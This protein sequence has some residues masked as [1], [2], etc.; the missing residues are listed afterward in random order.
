M[1]W[2]GTIGNV[3]NG[4]NSITQATLGGINAAQQNKQIQQ[5]Q[6]KMRQDQENLMRSE[7]K[8]NKAEANAINSAS[9]MGGNTQNKQDDK[10]SIS[11]GD[12]FSGS[13]TDSSDYGLTK[14]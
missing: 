12:S 5:Q 14:Y 6:D 1:D 4:I 3:I 13:L 9:A 11:G 8:Q 10:D 2:V 7:A